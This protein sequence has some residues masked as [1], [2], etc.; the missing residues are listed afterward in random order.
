MYYLFYAATQGKFVTKSTPVTSFNAVPGAPTV[1]S[2]LHGYNI[3][4]QTY[5]LST[6]DEEELWFLL[7][8]FLWSTEFIL[9]LGHIM[10]AIAVA[11]WYF[12]SKDDRK[13]E[14]A[15]WLCK[16]IYQTIRYHLGTAAFGSLVIAIMEFIRVVVAYIEKQLMKS[17]FNNCVSR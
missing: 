3:T 15:A 6:R 16:G 9:S 5:E 8:C 1:P 14:G 10:I 12:S 2:Y 4:Y 11:N 13:I 7:F 17:G